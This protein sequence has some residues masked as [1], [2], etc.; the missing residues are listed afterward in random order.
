MLYA[1]LIHVLLTLL[2]YLSYL[3]PLRL[4]VMINE[5]ITYLL[6]QGLPADHHVR[7]SSYSS[8]TLL[9]HK[10]N[11]KLSVPYGQTNRTAFTDFWIFELVLFRYVANNK[12]DY[13]LF[14][15]VVPISEMTRQCTV[16]CNMLYDKID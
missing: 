5:E 9:F 4:T 16:T 13:V 11:Q 8:T 14:S 6:M 7:P 3:K 10:S 15:L 1:I 2:T 12:H